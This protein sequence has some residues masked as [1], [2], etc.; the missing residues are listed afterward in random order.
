MQR[1]EILKKQRT[2]IDSA[3]SEGK[4]VSKE[5]FEECDKILQFGVITI[6]VTIW[7]QSKISQVIYMD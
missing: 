6:W 3:K 4:Q 7:S 5:S 1:T 2:G